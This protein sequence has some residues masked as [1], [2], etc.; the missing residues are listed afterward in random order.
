VAG[1]SVLTPC[2][3]RHIRD[4]QIIPAP[5]ARTCD[6]STTVGLLI[7]DMCVLQALQ[8]QRFRRPIEG[9]SVY[10]RAAG[11]RCTPAN[12]VCRQEKLRGV[13]CS[14]ATNLSYRGQSAHQADSAGFALRA[15]R[16]FA[17][18]SGIASVHP[19]SSDPA[20]SASTASLA[21]IPGAQIRPGPLQR[22]WLASVPG[23]QIR[24]GPLRRHRWHPSLELRSGPPSLAGVRPYRA[25]PTRHA[26]EA[27]VAQSYF[28]N[29]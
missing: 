28:W 15:Y 6:S 23:A 14:S 13:C 27:L 2:P 4:A 11:G 5:E 25:S 16:R 12:T 18:A 10:W 3:G 26:G 19:W 20:R 7:Y 21:S 22:R 24:P 29:G 8:I 17:R 9:G 1:S